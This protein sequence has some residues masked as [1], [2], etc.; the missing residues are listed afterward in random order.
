MILPNNGKVVVFD[1]QPKDIESLLKALSTTGIPFLYYQDELGDDL[2]ENPIENIRLVFLDLELVVNGTTPHNIISPIAAR[3]KRVL[4]KN[5]TYILV[6]WSTKEEKYRQTLEKAFN[7]TLIDYKP[8]MILSLN[9][10]AAKEAPNAADYVKNA[11]KDEMQDFSSLNAFMLWESAVNNAAGKITNG[12]T[13]IYA[14][15]RN[16]DEKNHALLYSLAKA[17]AGDD[18]VRGLDN[19]GKLVAAF[20]LINCNLIDTVED[21]FTSGL[22]SITLHEIVSGNPNT[23]IAEKSKINTSLHVNASTSFKHFYSGNLYLR[24]M[25]GTGREIIQKNVNANRINDLM[26]ENTKVVCLDVT[27]SCDYSADKNYSRMLYGIIID[28]QKF[29][30]NDIKNS[31]FLYRQ[32]PIMQIDRLSYLFFEL[33]IP[34]APFC[35]LQFLYMSAPVL[36]PLA[37]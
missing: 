27:P 1:D 10:A 25:D 37:E 11:L 13:S 22:D 18:S 24:D 6:Y 5:N 8:I 17:Q 21:I 36:P 30:K 14:K 23:S 7:T 33:L 19:N 32:C 35:F 16:W 28:G 34:F 31:Q 20:D 29:S 26:K 12:F 2:P 3:L 15:D 4:T 9:K